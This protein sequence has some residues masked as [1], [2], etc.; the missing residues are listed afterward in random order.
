MNKESRAFKIV[1]LVIDEADEQSGIEAISVVE[2]PAIE[3]NFVA[4]NKHE[5][6][7]KEVDSEKR[8]LMGAALV[9]N[10]QI[11][12]RNDKTNEEYYIYFSED[13]VRKASELFFKKSNHQNATLEHSQKVDGTTIVESWI[14][15]NSKTDKSALYGM[16]MPKG[17]WMV[18]M[19][20]DNED[21][22]KKAVNKEIRGFSIEGYFADKYDLNTESLKDLEERFTVEELKELLSKEELESYSDYPESVSNNAKRGIELNKAVGN[23][24]ATQVGKVRAQQL[25]N[26][27]PVSERTIKR[28]FSY[29]SRAEVYY[30]QG[31]KESCGYISYLLWGG[32]SAKTWAESKLKQIEREDLASMVI[33]EDFAIIDDRL[34]YATEDKAKEMAKD[35]GVEGIHEHEYE[36]KTWY[37]VGETHTVDMYG[38]CPKG[39]K[40][41]NGKCIRK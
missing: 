17:T 31:D 4:L 32:K 13:T 39:Y 20:I 21:I 15:E 23:K 24:C 28:M 35:L 34:A 7:L 5:I 16:D 33:D 29:L 40:K 19:K 41:K 36:G 8:I 3:E 38:K 6:L 11:Y 25:A 2:S 1:E 14:V 26:G 18:S 9:P 27:E 37:M 12:R 30:D 10:K 22:Y